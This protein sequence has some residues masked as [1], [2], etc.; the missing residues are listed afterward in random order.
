MLAAVIT[1]GSLAASAV[2][3]IGLRM[4]RINP[5]RMRVG[6]SVLGV[7]PPE[8]GSKDSSSRNMGAR[9]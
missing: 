4:L 5:P 1:L 7:E 6:D 2:G 9:R 8:A 3:E